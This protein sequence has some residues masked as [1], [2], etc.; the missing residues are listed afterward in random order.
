MSTSST[1]VRA[2]R[3]EL[4]CKRTGDDSEDG[5]VTFFERERDPDER[6]TRWITVRESDLVPSAK[7]R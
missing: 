3:P 7:W 6:T 4:V 5:E 1:R 2:E